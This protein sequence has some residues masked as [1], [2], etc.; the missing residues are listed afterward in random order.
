[1]EIAQYAAKKEPIRQSEASA[2]PHSGR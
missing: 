2:E 1:M